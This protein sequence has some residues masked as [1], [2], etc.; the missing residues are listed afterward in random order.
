MC[1]ECG[2][3]GM[4]K[5]AD[6]GKTPD[7][8]R[9]D[10]GAVSCPNE[11]MRLQ[12]NV[13]ASV[14]GYLGPDPDAVRLGLARF[15]ERTRTYGKGESR[16]TVYFSQLVEQLGLERTQTLLP[17]LARLIK[18]DDLRRAL[19]KCRCSD[20]DLDSLAGL[21]PAPTPRGVGSVAPAQ[22][23]ETSAA[24]PAPPAAVDGA[25]K[26]AM[27]GV[28]DEVLDGVAEEVEREKEAHVRAAMGGLAV[29]DRAEA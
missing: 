26:G 10:P 29:D 4:V 27:E 12:Q 1:E 8:E 2:G 19:L 21:A 22:V 25:T 16:A 20:L 13:L 28:M 18:D 24:P 5:K 7:P 17:S 14:R 3:N 11:E 15:A 9:E 6:W 23:P